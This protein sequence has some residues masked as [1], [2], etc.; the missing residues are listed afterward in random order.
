[1]PPR[2]AST[3]VKANCYVR[4]CALAPV[5]LISPME[6]S[7]LVFAGLLGWLAFQQAPT[8]TSLIGVVVLLFGGV[9]LA[10]R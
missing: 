7:W 1:M 6:Y 3:A 2:V 10:R 8:T 5:F 4:T 9:L